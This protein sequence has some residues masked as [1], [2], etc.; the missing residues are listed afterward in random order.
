MC[1]LGQS[2][3]RRSLGKLVVAY[4]GLSFPVENLSRLLECQCASVALLSLRF[5]C[6]GELFT[7]VFWLCMLLCQEE[8]VFSLSQE[9]SISF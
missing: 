3:G 1:G 7:R 4:R 2:G 8:S 9:S 5:R 6:L